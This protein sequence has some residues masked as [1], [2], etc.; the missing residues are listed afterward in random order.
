MATA[1]NA[2]GNVFG[3]AGQF[4]QELL[5]RSGER[6]EARHVDT[7]DSVEI[8]PV[9]KNFEFSEV[10]RYWFD[11]NPMI[12]HLMNAMSLTFPDGEHF[13]VRSVRAFRNSARDERQ[14][15]QIAGFIGQE[16]MHSLE[17]DHFNQM[18]GD[19]GYEKQAKGGVKLARYMIDRMTARQT[20][21]Q[22]L[23]ATAALEHLTA[24]L[25]SW[26]LETNTIDKLHPSVR[27][28]WLWHGIEETEHKAVAFD[29][30]QQVSGGDYRLRVKALLPAVTQVGIFASTYVV[31]FLAADGLSRRPS[32]YIKGFRELLRPG[33]MM[34]MLVPGLLAY[35]RPDFHPWQHDQSKQLEQVKATLLEAERQT[36]AA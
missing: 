25:G 34:S 19:M 7:P 28:L 10:P 21:L 20:P 23:A 30:L 6:F 5:R 31:Q 24:I 2:V 33:G 26:L 12:T 8:K 13:F 4:V 18:L 17:H 15:Q 14:K 35:Y 9:R 3:N 1:T 11:E 29:L 36:M 32:V 27:A 22:N 16:A